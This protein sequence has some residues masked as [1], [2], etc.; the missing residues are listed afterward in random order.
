MQLVIINQ[1]GCKVSSLL[2][3]NFEKLQIRQL[4]RSQPAKLIGGRFVE[5]KRMGRLKRNNGSFSHIKPPLK[6][7]LFHI[8]QKSEKL[9]EAK[10]KPKVKIGDRSFG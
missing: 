5:E 9:R 3:G 4:Q 7:G 10:K 2:P 8:G 1:F 6:S